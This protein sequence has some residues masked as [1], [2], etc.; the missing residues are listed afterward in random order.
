MYGP[1]QVTYSFVGPT[2]HAFFV[3]NELHDSPPKIPAHG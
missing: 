3:L 1:F 2:Q